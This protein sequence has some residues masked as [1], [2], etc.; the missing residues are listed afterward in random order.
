MSR[1]TANRQPPPTLEAA[2]RAF[3]GGDIA[4]TEHICAQLLARD[5]NDWAA[6]SLLTETALQR[7]RQDA[8]IVCAER[9]S[10]LAGDNPIPHILKAKC[11]F[12]TGKA[13]EALQAAELAEA[14]VGAAPEALDAL[15]AMFGLLGL[16][17]RAKS[18]LLRAVAGRAAVPQ[19]LFNLAATERM[20]G[21]LVDAEAHCDAALALQPAYGLAHYLRSDLRIQS[22]DRN[23]VAEMETALASGGLSPQ[24]E[25]MVRFT[26]GKECEDLDR[27]ERAFHHVEAGCA[28]QRRL[29]GRQRIDGVAEIERIIGSHTRDW[30]AAAPSGHASAAPVFVA[31]LPRTGT[32]LVERIIASHPAMTSVG[33]TGAFAAELRRA[34]SARDPARLGRDYMEAATLSR[35]PPNRRFVDKTLDNYLYCGL[36]H[37]ALPAARIILVQR[38]PMDACWAMYKAHFQGKFLFSYDQIEL[39]EYYLAYRRLSQHWKATLPPHALLEI[40]YEDVVRDQEATSRRMI[41]FAGL[42]WDQ[43]VLRFHES[44]APS[45]TASAVQVRRPIYASSLGKWRPHADAL[46]PL[47]ARLMRELPAAALA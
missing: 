25:V 31:G 22:E 7:G 45:A 3:S 29:L 27:H 47:R 44:P 36:I 39:A 37:V 21:A 35:L 33:E 18:L 15:G 17:E 16:H 5:A 23:H 43:E 41:S 19:Y 24:S 40:N 8:A 4:A 38:S 11:L 12:L 32:T 46:A 10:A 28:L 20:T 14:S 2:R 1:A 30:I 9:A 26:L 6:W 13:R 34:T 42:P